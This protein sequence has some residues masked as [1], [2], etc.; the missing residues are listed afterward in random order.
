VVVKDDFNHERQRFERRTTYTDHVDDVYIE[1]WQ[2][3]ESGE[4]TFSKRGRL[5]DQSVHGERTR[6]AQRDRRPGG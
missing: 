1:V 4:V 6:R 3:S 5:S 2:D